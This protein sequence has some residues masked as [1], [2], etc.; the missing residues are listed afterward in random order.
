MINM[1]DIN[2]SNY[3][4]IKEINVLKKRGRKKKGEEP[5]FE[6]KTSNEK[7]L[8]FIAPS[9]QTKSSRIYA[10]I[11]KT[12][13]HFEFTLLC[14]R[15]ACS[16]CQIENPGNGTAQQYEDEKNTLEKH[17]SKLTDIKDYLIQTK[18]GLNRKMFFDGLWKGEDIAYINSR[19]EGK[20]Y[21]IFKLI[22]WNRIKGV[23][24]QFIERV[25]TGELDKNKLI[26]DED[27]R[28][29][30][31]RSWKAKDIWSAAYA[32][33]MDDMVN[34]RGLNKCDNENCKTKLFFGKPHRSEAGIFCSVKCRIN[35]NDRLKRQNP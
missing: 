9:Q 7:E 30:L 19:I 8:I 35:T 1:R 31:Q 12:K 25:R 22:Y 18:D 6:E 26:P 23:D 5:V 34:C 24:K 2:F 11:V 17:V 27:F 33:L 21:P 28:P 32:E 16:P 4:D 3:S 14:F 20:V 15:I 10:E 29:Y 13:N